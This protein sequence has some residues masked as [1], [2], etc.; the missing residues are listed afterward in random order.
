[1][2]DLTL[3]SRLSTTIA[4]VPDQTALL[5]TIIAELQPVFDFYDVGLFVVNEEEDYHI[6]LATEAPEISPSEANLAAHLVAAGK[7]PHRDSLI[8]WMIEQIAATGKP[9]LFDF[10]DLIERFPD[11]PQSRILQ[12]TGYRDCLATTLRVRGELIGMFCLNSLKKDHFR[13][14]QFALFQAVADQ[15]AITLSHILAREEVLAQKQRVEQLLTISQ[16]ITEVSDRKQLLKTIYQ[17]IKPIFPYDSYGLFV[18][19]EDGQQHYEIIDA[20]VMDYES[21]I[22]AIEQQ[23]GAHYHYPHPD[24][25]IELMMQQGPGLFRLADYMNHD[26]APL[27]YEAGIRQLIAGPLSYGGEPIGML[28]FNSH[29]E[30]GYSEADL[31]LFE[32]IAEQMSVAVANVLANERVLSEKDQLQKLYTLSEVMTTV[33]HRSQLRAAFDRIRAFFPFDSAGL[34]VVE[35]E[36]HYE[37]L[38]SDTLP[39][40]STQAQIEAQFGRHARYPHAHSPVEH[41]MQTDEVGLYSAADLLERFPDYP[42]NEAVRTAGLQQVIAAPLHRN[43]HRIGLLNFNSK[44]ADQYG[45]T[46]LAMM[47][48]IAEQMSTVVSNILA[49]ERLLEEKQFKESLL[50]ISEAA[51]RIRDREGLYRAV[52]QQLEPLISFDDVVVIV[53]SQDR[54]TYEYILTLS[55]PERITHPL[56]SKIVH[57]TLRVEGS[58]I[59]NLFEQDDVTHYPLSEWL[60]HFPDSPGLQL[61]KDTGLN[62]SIIVK[63][64]HGGE[65]FG[66][67]I[68]HFHQ[69]QSL[70]Q[71]NRQFYLNIADQFSIVVSNILAN[72]REQEERQFKETLL[73]ISEAVASVQNRS[74][75]LRVVF[76]KI[77]PV[78]PFDAPGLF[79]VD[80]DQHYEILDNKVTN[81]QHN[82]DVWQQIGAGPFDN[83]TSFVQ[84]V[85]DDPKIYIRTT[86]Q[87][88]HPHIDV[89]LE[90]GLKQIFYG[91]LKNAGEVIGIF[92]LN[93][94]QAD[95]Y[96]ALHTP[97]F[98]AIAD[99]LAV[100]VSNVLANEQI[101][102]RAEE[103]ARELEL[104]KALEGSAPLSEQLQA[105][106]H[107]LRPALP[108]DMLSLAV[109]TNAHSFCYHFLPTS[110]TEFQV[111]DK[112]QCLSL[113]D[114]SEADYQKYYRQHP[115]EPLCCPAE[116]AHPRPLL[117]QTMRRWQ[118]QSALVLPLSLGNGRVAHLSLF[119]RQRD[120]S[121]A[122]L[123]RL[124]KLSDTLTLALDR[125]LGQREIAQLNEQLQQE[126][127]Y[128]LEEVTRQYHFGEMIGESASLQR[129]F[130]QIEQV[131]F[132]DASVLV[133]GE[134]GTGKELIARAVHQA[135]PRQAH[136]L[137]K[138]NCAAIPEALFESELFGHEK[139]AFTGAVQQRVGKFE[140]AHRGTVF[141][142]E[143]GELPLS[144]QSKLLRVL[145]EQEFERVGGNSPIKSNFRVVAATNRDLLQEIAAGKFRADLYYRLST[146]PVQLLPLRERREDI[147]LL[148][149]HFAKQYSQHIGVK[150]QGFTPAALRSLQHYAF[151]GQYPRAAQHGRARG[152][153]GRW[154][155]VE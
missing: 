61:M 79:I 89:M 37:L 141:L 58:N 107:I 47:Q 9:V 16:A 59:A 8:A 49:N 38:D 62:D 21:S 57:Q 135:S 154:P 1:M 138:V 88:V 28:C 22:V 77:Q 2:I 81:D 60:L 33:Q 65:A 83:R 103:K 95:Q 55:P 121:E 4:T 68:F 98:Q 25:P 149:E 122:S 130:R 143:I 30:D 23:Y 85:L 108:Y 152:D 63:L 75:L 92:I 131:A 82:K 137:V 136:L 66:L 45:E 139:G 116:Q 155:A 27:M 15:V 124:H 132:T 32:A 11:Y 40:E 19:T 125:Q 150:Y 70:N 41:M 129:V 36:E 86:D 39:G 128:L 73:G 43:G 113:L 12:Q 51:T 145:Q 119:A 96:Q 14:E 91:P 134:T 31:P 90:T 7:I 144:M 80:G 84:E 109:E 72:E 18:L 110:A 29:Q 76:E 106:A 74:Q 126:N 50:S 5:R 78:L 52:M 104:I 142:D 146:F 3:L 140:L 64:R 133:Q 48:A 120:Y 94:K 101:K 42:Q 117:H 13:A 26:Q 10:A 97:L 111:L 105:L 99:Q 100:A 34:F 46:D 148:A 118:M 67:L 71:Q 127:T 6:D 102:A 114:L 20:E 53:T 115:T 93:A 54:T 17:R 112:A 151:P 24:S 123:G 56:Y 44:R 153:C 147:P 69:L 87:I 35:E